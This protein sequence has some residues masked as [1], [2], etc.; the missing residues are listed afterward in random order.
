MTFP[1]RL[2]LGF[3]GIYLTSAHPSQQV[4]LWKDREEG[5]GE[6]AALPGQ[7]PGGLSH[8]GERNH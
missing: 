5:R 1:G 8:S 7:P 3:K 6:A 2:S 4:V